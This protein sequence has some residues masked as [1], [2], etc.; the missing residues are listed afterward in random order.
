M[1]V[2]DVDYAGE[3]FCRGC[4]VPCLL[5]SCGCGVWFWVDFV[6]VC[7]RYFCG[8]VLLGPLGFGWVFRR[9]LDW[10]FKLMLF[11]VWVKFMSWGFAV[12]GACFALALCVWES[13]MVL[14]WLR[15]VGFMFVVF[16]ASL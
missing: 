12:L 13:G 6:V 7:R 1:S 4:L 3:C 16:I 2:V 8:F 10:M 11:W 15:F 9:M 5:G 14:E